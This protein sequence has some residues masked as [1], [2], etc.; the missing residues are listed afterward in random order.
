[1]STH[2][3]H[4]Y[5]VNYGKLVKKGWHFEVEEP[6]EPITFKGAIMIMIVSK[7]RQL[8]NPE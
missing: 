2:D 7:I 4:F 1:M 8:I 6:A 3:Y 5:V